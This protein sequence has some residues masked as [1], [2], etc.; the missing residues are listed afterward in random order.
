MAIIKTYTLR[1]GSKNVTTEVGDSLSAIYAYNSCAD[2]R[3]LHV[4]YGVNYAVFAL[5]PE[6]N[7][8]FVFPYPLKSSDCWVITV[9][10]YS[11]PP[12][13]TG[14]AKEAESDAVY[15]TIVN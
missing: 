6:V 15:V 11:Q 7:S 9:S 4:E 8:S 3:F 2:V 14:L 1:T 5:P 10:R 13:Q 12:E